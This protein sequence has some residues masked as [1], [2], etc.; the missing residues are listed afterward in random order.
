MPRGDGRLS[1]DLL[2]GE[3]GPQDA[4]G[5]FGVWAPERGRRQAHLLRPLRPAAPRPGVG[6]D[7]GQRTAASCSST[8]TWAWSRRSST[9]ARSRPSRATSPSATPAT[10]PPARSTLGERPA[11]A[12]QHRGGDRR[13]RPQRQPHQHR[14]AARPRRAGLRRGSAGSE[15][16]RRQHHRHRPHHDAARRLARPH[17][18]G[19]GPGGAAAAAGRVLAGVHGRA[20]ALRGSRPAR[21]PPARAR[22]AGARLGGRVARPPPSTSSARRSSARSSRASWSRSTRTACAHS[23]SRRPT[24]TGCVFEYVY[25]AR[26]DTTIA[27]RGVHAARVEM[28]RRLAGEHPVEADL[29]IPTPESGTPG[30]DRVRRGVRH[31]VRPGPGEER[32]RRTHLHPAVPDHPPARHPAQAQPAARR[33]RAASASSWSTTRSSAATPSGRW[34]GCCA[35]RA[36][37]RCTCGSRPRR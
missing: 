37:P 21:R 18:R 14:R 12:R 33:H 20:H 13:P 10:P 24:P 34:C 7:R 3:K 1:H 9:S 35:R 22:P 31:P 8:R 25:L 36:R 6:G 17:P 29:V 19:H 32:L 5:V 26:P 4:C 28:G 16:A 2:P 23:V 15:L 30:G 27:G 11:H